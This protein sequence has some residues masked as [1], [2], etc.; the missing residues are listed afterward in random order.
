MSGTEHPLQSKDP[1]PCD[2]GHRFGRCCG[3]ILAGTT[4]AA[5][6]AS[7]MRSRYTAF[8]IG[9][10]AYLRRSWDPATCPTDIRPLD[11][12]TWLGL[13]IK[14]V[15]AGTAA[16]GS[17]TVTFVARYKIAGRA[18]RLQECSRFRKVEGRWYYVDGEVARDAGTTPRA[19]RR[20]KRR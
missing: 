6:A 17:G 7:L 5:T 9:D 8:V 11:D 20:S 13:T 1:C 19:Q 18:H 4:P 16:D 14:D 3:P 10:E 2:S 12:R 15:K